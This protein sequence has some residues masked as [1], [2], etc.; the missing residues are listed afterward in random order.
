[1]AL[2]DMSQEQVRQGYLLILDYKYEFAYSLADLAGYKGDF[3]TFS[4]GQPLV[5]SGGGVPH[6]DDL[7]YGSTSWRS[8]GV[9]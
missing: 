6:A 5:V 8:S 7:S 4:G 1:M 9:P 3:P 2:P